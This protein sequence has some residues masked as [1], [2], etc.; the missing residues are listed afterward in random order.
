M[1]KGLLVF[2][3]YLLPLVLV[4]VI[5]YQLTTVWVPLWLRGA[6]LEGRDVSGLMLENEEGRMVA[7]G[8]Y[9]GRSV[10]VNFW[11]SWCLPCRIEIPELAA[12]YP[13]LQKQGKVLLGV[14]LQESWPVIE[15]FRNEV[16]IP[17][18]VLRDNGSV[19]NA[20]GISLIPVL[21]VINE[22]SQVDTI[23]YGFRPWVRWYLKWFI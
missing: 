2:W 5:A 11:A 7:L 6:D 12:V 23:V 13:E 15:K 3:R 17:F 1:K 21:V 8:D 18:P 14:N 22:E 16:E 19:S 9:K 10:V 4:G 20:L